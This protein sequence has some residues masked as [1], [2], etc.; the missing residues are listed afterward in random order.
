VF[1]IGEISRVRRRI[2]GDHFLE[3][4]GARRVV[5]TPFRKR[6]SGSVHRRWADGLRPV[7]ECSSP[8]SSPAARPD[9]QFRRHAVPLE[10][11]VPIVIRSPPAAASTAVRSIRKSRDVVRPTSA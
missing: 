9:R 7:A 8:I 1:C 2:Q 5:D 3:K 10:C 6:P 4:F 11:R